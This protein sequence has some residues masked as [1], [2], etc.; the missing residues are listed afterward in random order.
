MASLLI[1]NISEDLRKKLKEQA[2]L[3]HR[4]INKQVISILEQALT[5]PGIGKL[6]PPVKLKFRLT[7][8]WLNKAK[9]LGR[10]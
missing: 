10:L 1:K 6:P 5:R 3:N 4:S 2:E 8:A 9:R 7:N